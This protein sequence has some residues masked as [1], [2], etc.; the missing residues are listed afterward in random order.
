MREEHKF[1]MVDEL[2]YSHLTVPVWQFLGEDASLYSGRF[3]RDGDLPEDLREALKQ[4]QVGTTIP[5]LNSTFLHDFQFFMS[6]GGRDSESSAAV[7]KRYIR[8]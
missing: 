8:D 4:S 1:E 6:Q 3:V 5:F 7:V 2:K